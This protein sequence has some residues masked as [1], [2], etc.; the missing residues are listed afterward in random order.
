MKILVLSLLLF[1]SP[2]A[3][4]AQD[5]PASQASV[6]FNASI[7]FTYLSQSIDPITGRLGS[8]RAGVPV[9]EAR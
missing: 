3:T 9:T 1:A 2:L 8:A 6:P 5:A 4:A 7:D